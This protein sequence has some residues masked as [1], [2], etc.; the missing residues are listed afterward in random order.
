MVLAYSNCSRIE[1][2]N[3]SCNITA[4]LVNYTHDSVGKVVDST[5]QQRPLSDED[6]HVL[7]RLP[8]P[9]LHRDVIDHVT[10]HLPM[11]R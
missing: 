4:A 3:R 10:T 6:S 5:A 1:Y 7:L 8:E 9:R 2:S 11:L